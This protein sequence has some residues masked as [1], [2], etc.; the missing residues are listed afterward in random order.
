MVKI[1]GAKINS[2]LENKARETWHLHV[3]S[4]VVLFSSVITSFLH[5]VVKTKYFTTILKLREFM[6][7][8]VGKFLKNL[9][10]MNKHHLSNKILEHESKIAVNLRDS[11]MVQDQIS[12]RPGTK[13]S[14]VTD[15]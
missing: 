10:R 8:N 1:D 7:W 11:V 3:T 13:L 15:L 14:D 5:K 4:E 6:T 9:F 2:V 12:N